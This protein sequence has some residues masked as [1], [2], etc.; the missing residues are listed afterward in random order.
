MK[1]NKIVWLTVVMALA[2]MLLQSCF[3]GVESTPKLTAKD[4]RKRHAT[5]TPEVVYMASA[6]GQ[7]TSAWQPGKRFYVTDSRIGLAFLPVDGVGGS[8]YASDLGGKDITLQ[9]IGSF[10]SI[11]GVDEVQLCFRAPDGTSLTY[12]PGISRQDFM[13]RKSF[14]VPFTVEYD[15]VDSV[16]ALLAGN[17]Y[18]ILVAR[19]LDADGHETD[20]LR[21]V[22]VTIVDVQPGNTSQPLK[23]L[24]RNEDGKVQMLMMTV[25]TEPTSTRN[26]NTL[27]A[28][29]NPRKKYPAITDT[30]WDLITR[31]KVQL[32]MTQQECRLALGAPHRYTRVPTTAGMGEIWQ[33]DNGAVLQFVDGHLERCNF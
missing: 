8:G 27:F 11:T 31:S 10:T 2:A 12:R 6:S 26:F 3:T 33:Y 18:Y 13:Q 28:F 24:F 20:G 22:P 14:A 29:A 21:Y 1:Y 9:E 32:G 30:V 25:G 17:T 7:P 16:R 4:I 5:D 19:R 23:V 15:L